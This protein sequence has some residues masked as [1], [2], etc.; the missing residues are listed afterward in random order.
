MSTFREKFLR[1]F[2]T[3]G[4]SGSRPVLQ[5][6]ILIEPDDVLDQLLED[7]GPT[8]F[9]GIW[10]EQRIRREF[11][12][13]QVWKKLQELGYSHA[14]L[15]LDISDPYEHRLTIRDSRAAPD[16]SLIEIVLHCTTIPQKQ[17]PA[18]LQVPSLRTLFVEW[19]LL[20]HPRGNFTEERPRLPGQRYP[21]LG[22]SREMFLILFRLACDLEVHALAVTPGH[23]HNA[24]IF[25]RR[26]HY[27][28]PESEARLRCYVRDFAGRPLAEVSWGFELGCVREIETGRLVHW[29][30]DWQ[31]AAA[32][33]VLERFFE[34]ASYS[35][36]IDDFLKRHH[37]EIDEELFERKKPIIDTLADLTT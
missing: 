30:V 12:R 34:S 19:M 36:P 32:S 9:M 29:F 7:R 25:S 27:L 4:E 20:Q 1:K 2:R 3:T 5:K 23:Y 37:Y 22:L 33:E 8:R 35:A 6:E 11:E 16:V 26:L 13:H 14:S 31:A 24:V 10:D 28:R 21:G 15:R 17:L 18:G